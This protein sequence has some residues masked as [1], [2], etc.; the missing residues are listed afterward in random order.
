MGHAKVRSTP[1]RPG[2]TTK[3]L[4]P[5]GPGTVPRLQRVLPEGDVFE[6]P[7]RRA[8]P[9]GRRVWCPFSLRLMEQ[10]EAADE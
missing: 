6:P 8:F 4:R 9:H 5:P 3:V 10:L 2:G 1:Q 7:S